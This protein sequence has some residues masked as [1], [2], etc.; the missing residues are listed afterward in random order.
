M[1]PLISI[2]L[3]MACIGI[4]AAKA[5]AVIITGSITPTDAENDE[6]YFPIGD[7]VIMTKPNSIECD[8]I[9]EHLLNR[10]GKLAF[11]IEE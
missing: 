3:L 1:F 8:F 9:R 10:P 11:I 2:L 5:T 6:C 7:V 4:Y